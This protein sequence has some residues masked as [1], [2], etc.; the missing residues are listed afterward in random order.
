MNE[1]LQIRI[2]AD[3][4]DLNK[5][6]GKAK[7]EVEEFG[8]QGKESSKEFEAA[9]KDAK[10]TCAN[11]MKAMSAAIVG[12]V[13]SMTALAESTREMRTNQAKLETA[14][15]SAGASAE[16]ATKVYDDL[17]RVLGDDGQATEAANHLAKLTTNQAE[18]AEW[19]NICKGVYATFG[20]SLPI[21]GLTEA[22][23][24][25]A[26][27]GQVTGS[28]A[29][30]LNWAGVNEDEFNESLAACND[31]A[32]RER[33]IRKTLNELYKKT[34]SNYEKNSKAV[35]DANDAQN[36]LN[37]QLAETGE[38]VEPVATGIKEM[39]AALL[40]DAQK[41]IKEITKYLT[42]TVFPAIKKV[43]NFI[44]ANLPEIVGLISGMAAGYIAYKAAVLTSTIATEGLTIAQKALNLAM[45]MN[46]V[47]LIAGAFAALTVG[48]VAYTSSIDDAAKETSF[49]TE[50]ERALIAS[51][52]E[53][54][55]ALRE[56]I[57]AS[58]ELVGNIQAEAGYY[59]NLTDELFLLADEQGRVAG[60]DEARAQFIINQLNEAY[61]LEIQ[62]VDGVIVKYGELE[63]SI[64]D[65]I[66]AKTANAMLEAKNEAYLEALHA[67][68]EALQTVILREKDLAAQQ[69]VVDDITKQKT[70]A[71]DAYTQAVNSGTT[72]QIQDTL[73]AYNLL[74]EKYHYELD[75]LNGK[76]A[77]Y[78]EAALAY[79]QHYNTIT[80]YENA[81][82]L[83]QQ[84]NY[85]EAISMLKNKSGAFFD[86]AD[87]VDKATQESLDALFKEVIQTGI[88]AEQTKQNF[89]DGVEGYTEQMVAEAN[90]A[91]Q[92]ALAAWSSAY[93]DANGIG[94]DIADGFGNGMDS[95]KGGLLA[96]AKSIVSAVIAAMRK[97]ADSH[98]P[99][100]KTIALG[101]DM[102]AG[103]EIGIT[104]STKD[105]AKASTNLVKD[106]LKALEG[107]SANTFTHSISG[108]ITAAS[109]ILPKSI[110]APEIGGLLSAIGGKIG[111]SNT[112][113]V[114]Q[115]DGKTF[116][117]TAINT[118][119]AQTKQTGK[120]QLLV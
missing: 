36:K 87:D 44:K 29:D 54:T 101:K 56:Q 38:A 112:P 30:A 67:E 23:N 49:L 5:N 86:Y 114:I 95:K 13:A 98:S 65:V 11:A 26:K 35:L 28:L 116:A 21:E 25:T 3:T 69:A 73:E 64:Y 45:S 109:P 18:L 85:E 34:A 55:E 39:G 111:A 84:G 96:K 80:E 40:K 76:Q 94:G 71:W 57:K 72:A 15:E 102:G 100:K 52:E 33:L 103:A 46:P 32:E 104:Q 113:I 83:I 59:K 24:E 77:A 31:E 51:S 115:V 17:Y 99:S 53:A 58:N 60:N 22:A 105:V 27:V 4:S 81:A 41:P 117:T 88:A 8:E 119:N 20:D 78:D 2:T 42:N 66:S 12:A 47:G 62:M 92:L 118:I 108:T 90:S 93:N 9:L 61:G 107:F 16:V 89:E 120:L 70:A 48:I 82:M 1:E 14:F 43:Y 79:G 19:T 97:E 50:E 68:D 75:I 91:Y 63:N 7:Q 10:Q 110:E 6:M 37:K 106:S 74:E